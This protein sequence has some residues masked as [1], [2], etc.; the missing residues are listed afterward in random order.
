MLKYAFY[1]VSDHIVLQNKLINLVYLSLLEW[2]T[3]FSTIYSADNFNSKR[4]FYFIYILDQFQM[5]TLILFKEPFFYY[6]YILLK[7]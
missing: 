5:L 4:I 6:Y 3:T 2:Q 1:L 7:I